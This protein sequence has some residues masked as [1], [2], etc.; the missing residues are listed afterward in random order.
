MKRHTLAFNA[1][2]LRQEFWSK[3]AVPP[4]MLNRAL[5]KLNEKLDAK[6]T[7]FF[8]NS[9]IVTQEKEV[10]AHDIQLQ[11]AQAIAKIADAFPRERATPVAAPKFELRIENGV[12][13][14]VMGSSG[15]E[16]AAYALNET[17]PDPTQARGNR[18]LAP[19]PLS[20]MDSSQKELFEFEEREAQV[21]KIPQKRELRREALRLLFN[22]DGPSS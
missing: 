3:V 13:S 2:R 19:P 5:H 10:E 8:T 12:F 17:N 21:I 6:E 4:E 22:E 14:L 11:A 18:Q 15:G 1:E 20:L 9:G 7:K 16:E